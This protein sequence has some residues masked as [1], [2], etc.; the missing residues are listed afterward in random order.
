MACV[1]CHK[2]KIKCSA[3]GSSYPCER[4][5]KRSR[6]HLC[7]QHISRQGRRAE[8]SSFTP[9][10]GLLVYI[11][12]SLTFAL[13]RRSFPLLSEVVSLADRF[14][15]PME[16]AFG[17][18]QSI[19]L[20]LSVQP[21]SAFQSS[22]LHWRDFPVSLLKA[23]GLSGIKDT[24]Q[25]AEQLI[26]GWRVSKGQS[27][28][29]ASPAFDRD[30]VKF[31]ELQKAWEKSV[32]DIHSLYLSPAEVAKLNHKLVVL[33]NGCQAP[34]LVHAVRFQTTV[35]LVRKTQARDDLITL[36]S[37]LSSSP[38]HTVDIP[39]SNANA[40]LNLQI[41]NFDTEFILFQ[42]YPI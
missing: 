14:G 38:S 28:F 37:L 12:N 5:V 25:L 41:M 10:F 1:P 13:Q 29:F 35:H 26:F 7:M 33:R 16:K 27:S 23:S 39:V 2:A 36:S 9:Q 21:S 42:L 34:N 24:P 19:D 11:R 32:I 20:L 8:K 22:R 4:C 31:T 6:A 17:G 15:I 40:V 3:K 18:K 30:V